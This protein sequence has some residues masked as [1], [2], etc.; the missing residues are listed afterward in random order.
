MADKLIR[1]SD[2]PPSVRMGVAGQNVAVLPEAVLLKQPS[3]H[4]PFPGTFLNQVL[5]FLVLAAGGVRITPK[6]ETMVEMPQQDLIQDVT[7]T[8]KALGKIAQDEFQASH[9]P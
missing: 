8:A 1:Q 2:Q 7:K 9:P 5:L 3:C 4:F 6:E